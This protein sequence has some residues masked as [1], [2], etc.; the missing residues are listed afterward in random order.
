MATK[1]TPEEQNEYTTR[2][3]SCYELLKAQNNG[4]ISIQNLLDALQTDRQLLRTLE[5]CADWSTQARHEL[6]RELF[7]ALQQ[8]EKER[9]S[10][11]KGKQDRQA[12]MS[13]AGI[14]QSEE[15]FA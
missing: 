5:E 3:L 2:L 1:A 11:A 15:S 12:A 9:S 13:I 8:E 6:Y 4:S 10:F 14:K 7:V